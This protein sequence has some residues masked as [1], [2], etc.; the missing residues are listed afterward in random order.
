[1]FEMIP[2][3]TVIRMKTDRQRY[4]SNNIYV[5]V[6][7]FSLFNLHRKMTFSHK[8][9]S[10]QKLALSVNEAINVILH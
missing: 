6:V 5:S 9:R 3:H 1:M 2:L 4:V 7:L 10:K 8:Y